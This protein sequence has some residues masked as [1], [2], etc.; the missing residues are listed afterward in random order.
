MKAI[1]VEGVV[2]GSEQQF[3]IYFVVPEH[4]DYPDRKEPTERTIVV[5]NSL[6]D[7]VIKFKAETPEAYIKE[8]IRFN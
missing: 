5:A 3:M 8:I 1:T 7:A 4:D 6:K 2:E